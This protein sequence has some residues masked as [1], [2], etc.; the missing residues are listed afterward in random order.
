MVVY[1]LAVGLLVLGWWLTTCVNRSRVTG[2]LENRGIGADERV[3]VFRSLLEPG[4]AE[5]VSRA[6]LLRRMVHGAVS[7]IGASSG[8]FFQSTADHQMTRVAVAG[9]FPLVCQIDPALR[10]TLITRA[11]LI[12]HVL[13]NDARPLHGGW[14]GRIAE[15]GRG[16][17]LAEVPLDHQFGRPVDSSWAVG[18]VMGVP[19]ALRD[20]RSGVLVVV[21]A[22]SDAPF[23]ALEFDLLRRFA[24]VARAV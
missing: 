23:S 15:S 6:E 14:V 21:N 8:S 19:V 11:K 7:G 2:L 10:A 24:D 16:E 3:R 9:V 13:K 5:G 4:R 1:V 22:P 12:E 20:G 17:L 18:S